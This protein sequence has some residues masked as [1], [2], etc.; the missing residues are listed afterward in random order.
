ML[1]HVH[2]PVVNNPEFIRIQKL[3]LDKFYKGEYKLTIF[4]DAKGFADTSNFGDITLK[5]KIQS[6]CDELG[7]DCISIPNEED[8][9]K[10]SPSDRH[11]RTANWMWTNYQSKLEEPLLVLDSDMFLI[12][13]FQ[14]GEHA[15]TIVPQYRGGKIF[16][17]PNLWW[18]P[19]PSSMPSHDL[20]DWYSTSINGDTTDTG[21]KTWRFF[22]ANPNINKK[23]IKWQPSLQWNCANSTSNVSQEVLEFCQQDIKN[24]NNLFWCEIYEDTFLHLRAGSNWEGIAKQIH[25]KRTSQLVSLFNKI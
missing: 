1:L 23:L 17:W 20:I 10:K 19:N 16:A 14:I 3:S 9:Y 18:T 22:D 13:D 15:I 2:V 8:R 24:Q 4:N 25:D 12:S 21:G 7:I 6:T 11:S 5:T